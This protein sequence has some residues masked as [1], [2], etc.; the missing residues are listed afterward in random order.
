MIGKSLF[1]KETNIQPFV[2]LRVQLSTGQQ[3]FHKNVLHYVTQEIG[4]GIFPE[5]LVLTSF[6]RVSL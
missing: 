3:S 2:G 1:K 4:Y 5:K 6:G